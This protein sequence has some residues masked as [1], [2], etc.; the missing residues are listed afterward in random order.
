MISRFPPSRVMLAAVL[1]AVAI[2]GKAGFLF[3]TV[4][5]LPVVWPAAGVGLVATLVFGHAVWPA[6]ALG[7]FVACL[8][9]SG[10]A[11][12]SV[13]MAFGAV[14]EAFLGAALIDRLAG[15]A[16]ALSRS[17][18]QFRVIAVVALVTTPLAATLSAATGALTGGSGEEVG[19][20]WTTTWLG[21]LSGTLVVASFVSAWLVAPVEAIRPA[22]VVRA[23]AVVVLTTGVALVVFGGWLP[24]GRQ[25]Y[26]LEFLGIP[27]LIWAARLGRRETAT[28]VVLL[29]GIAI[30]GTFRGF[31]PFAQGHAFEALLLV[32]TFAAVIAI[33]GSV[34]GSAIAEHR[35]DQE[36]LRQ[37]AT[38]DSLTG[39]ANHRRLLEILRAEIAR[40]KR[41]ARPFAVVFMD[42]D[43]LKRIND[44]QGHL[45]GSRALSRLADILRTSCR[46]TDTP[47]RYGGDEFAIVLPE[48]TEE[49]GRVVLRRIQERLSADPAAP[50]LSVSGGVATFPRDGDSPTLL[51]RAADRLL[52]EAK[53]RSH[54]ARKAS[55]RAADVVPRTGTSF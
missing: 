22:R 32:Q 26:P 16:S 27:F 41:S 45:A 24:S 19:L 29:V 51:L 55:G 12:R 23:I 17:D 9:S 42:M 33:T 47:A 40:S 11:A 8:D 1:A 21:H 18:T 13:V 37:L 46:E 52:Y 30:W 6:I 5:G 15:G 43:G 54:A 49:G 53:A 3:G 36:Q 50:A 44:R 39:I 28:A 10:A 4:G 31:G 20:A 34:L 7:T 2:L 38:T 35:D 25:H 14:V 48:A